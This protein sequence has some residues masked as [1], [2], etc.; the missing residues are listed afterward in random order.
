LGDEIRLKQVIGN[1]ISNAIKYTK[2][3]EINIKCTLEGNDG[4]LLKFSV[5][6]S[7]KGISEKG[8]KLLFSN[9]SQADVTANEKFEGTGLGLSISKQLMKL[10]GGEVGVKSELGVGSTFWCTLPYEPENTVKEKK[11]VSKV[12]EKSSLAGFKVLVVDD[13]ETNLLVAEMMIESLGGEVFTANNGEE[14]LSHPELNFVDLILM[15][16]RMPGMNGMEVTKE[17]KKRKGFD[18]KI[19]AL[20]ANVFKEDIQTYLDSGMDGHIAK[21]MTL[22]AFKN[23]IAIHL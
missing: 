7:G 1:F 5:I 3:G 13:A 4:E 20:T 21:P 12:I 22:D 14:C 10:M 15:D 16:I 11:Y 8:Q 6:D 9:Y 18:T 23:A 2:Q 17:L 19:I